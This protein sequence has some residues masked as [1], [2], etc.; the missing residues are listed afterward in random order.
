MN[1]EY[2]FDQ[3]VILE[4][5]STW[6]RTIVWGIIGITA[7][8]IIWASIFKIDEA[9]PATGKLE[10]QGAVTDVKAPVSGVVKI[11]HV[12]DGQRVKK[13]DLLVTLEQ[14]TAKAQLISLQKNRSALVQ[15][16]DFYR[17]HLAGNVSSNLKLGVTLNIRPEIASLTQS[18]AAIVAENQVYRAQLSGSTH[19]VT[20]TPDQKLRLQSRESDFSSRLADIQLEK[21]K[22]I[23]KLSQNQLELTSAKNVLA[24]SQRIF[25]DMETVMKEGAFP[26]ARYLTQQQEVV[27]SQAEVARLM[28][29]QQQLKLAIAQSNEKIRNTEALSKEDLLSRITVNEKSI[30][31]IDS[32]LT[33]IILENQK[34]VN[35]IDSQ[36]SQSQ[37]TLKYQKISAP[38]DG[39]IFEMQPSSSGFVVNTTEPVVKIVP[40]EELVA[41]VYIT[42]R[43]IGFVR[44]GQ[45]VDVRI[46][47]FPFQEF[48]DI[49]GELIWIGSDALPPDQ[50]H[51]FYRFPAKV[52]LDKQSVLVSDR[53]LSLQSG[54]S[55]NAN[56]KLRQRTIMSIFTD[57]LV[58]KAESLKSI[59]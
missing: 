48:G 36:I 47:S 51:N 46:D 37:E 58:Q 44:Q 38:V 10:P 56:I 13:G 8:T 22:T 27:K 35:E 59:R 14:T 2:K 41:R 16:N 33:K 43:D 34:K 42:N 53:S 4:Q 49:K 11:V 39:T 17:R 31:E 19:G 5:S 24:I 12:K 32:Q 57:F 30:A 9:I 23:E 54:M 7:F 28:K 45:K 18:R 29:E 20:L 55:I 26:R 40:N 21:E 15:E 1:T 52:R 25:K 3:P 50:I 6:S